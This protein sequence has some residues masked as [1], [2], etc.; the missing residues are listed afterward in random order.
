MRLFIT[1]A[2][3]FIGRNFVIYALKENHDLSCLYRKNSGKRTEI[4]N[5]KL[6]WIEGTLES[7]LKSQLSDCDALIHLA[8]YGVHPQ[9]A[10]WGEAMRWNVAASMNL[11]EQAAHAGIKRIIVAGSCSEYGLSAERY[12]KVPVDA[13]LE[14]VNSYGASKAAA[15]VAALAMARELKLELAVLRL[16]HVYGDFEDP[17]RFW[18]SLKEAAKTGKNLEMTLGEQVRDFT[19]VEFV[20]E[21]LLHYSCEEIIQPGIPV[22]RNIGTGNPKTLLEFAKEKWNLLGA[23]GELLP[24]AIAYRDN[25]VMRYIPEV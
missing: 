9:F 5:K 18:P 21:K 16:F 15:S 13:P 17:R 7:D 20:A 10:S 23:R 2:T 8:A 6:N 25:E 3:G 14:P 1:G 4:F 12:K 19:P 24:G 22:L 11:I